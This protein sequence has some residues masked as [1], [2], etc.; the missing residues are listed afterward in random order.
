MPRSAGGIPKEVLA[1]REVQVWALRQKFFTHQRIADELGLERSTVTKMLQRITRRSLNALGDDIREKKV[2]QLE[3]LEYIADEAIQG[4]HRS[5]EAQKNVSRRTSEKS[6]RLVGGGKREETLIQTSDMDGDPR[7][8]ETAMRA[9]AEIRKIAGID[10]PKAVELSGRGGS[11][12]QVEHRGKVHGSVE[13]VAAVW[14]T[15]V[16]V[17]AIQLTDDDPAGNAEDDAIHNRDADA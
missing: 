15:L 5:K 3:Q 4:W 10:A 11:A 8:L 7:Y 2:A 17:G 9:L 6:G 16:E 13:H 14:E 12:L 1:E